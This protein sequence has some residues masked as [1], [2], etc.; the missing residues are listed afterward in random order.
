LK[1]EAIQTHATDIDTIIFD[2]G[3]VLVKQGQR[4]TVFGSYKLDYGPEEHA[5]W[6]DYKLGRCSEA[7]YWRRTLAGTPSAGR[8]QELA[9]LAALARTVYA[10][11]ETG[12]AYPLVRPLKDAG[13]RLAIL[14][15]HVSEWARPFVTKHG[16]DKLCDPVLISSE[17][18]LAKPNPAIYAYTLRA[19]GR[20]DAP[21][22]TVFIDDKIKNANAAQAAGMHA[23]HY[24]KDTDL[25]AELRA[26][27]VR[28][29]Q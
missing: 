19:V 6:Q 28:W 24:T 29:Q 27:G 23:I 26:L 10:K 22:R 9:E 8:E 3:G 2:I 17:I 11:A 13:Y 4:A 1:T 25:A 14:S 7:E 16:L 20:E 21:E 15:N 5:V 12:D 18:H